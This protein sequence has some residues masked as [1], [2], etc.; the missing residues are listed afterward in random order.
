M[1]LSLIDGL[2]AALCGLMLRCG[3]HNKETNM[4]HIIRSLL[5][6]GGLLTGFQATAQESPL[7]DALVEACDA[8]I[9]QYCSQV[10]PGEGRLLHCAAAHEDKLSSQC[11]YALYQAASLLEQVAVAIAYVAESCET[12]I[13]TMCRDVPVGEGRILACLEENDA[14]LGESCKTAITETAAE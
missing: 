13:T 3:A 7:I 1:T 9:K 2:P 11:T 12:E 8:D 10:T 6:A 14:K 5:I 4:K